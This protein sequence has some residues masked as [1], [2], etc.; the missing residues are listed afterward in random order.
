MAS[1]FAN[2]DRAS[3]H[4]F[5]ADD[6]LLFGHATTSE[7]LHFRYAIRLYEKVSGQQINPKKSGIFFIPNTDLSTISAILSI[8][9]MPQVTGHGKYLGLPSIVGKSKKEVF[10]C[11]KDKVWYKLQGWK[12]RHLSQ[13]GEETLIKKKDLDEITVLGD[14]SSVILTTLGDAICP[15]H[16]LSVYEDIMR[17]KLSAPNTSFYWTRR[18]LNCVAHELAFFAKNMSVLELYWDRSP[19]FLV[20]SPLDDF[21]HN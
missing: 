17:L 9:G 18:C 19:P 14:A 2:E 4:L 1:Q 12:E 7:A 13:A 15:I 6:T 10:A 16:C 5:F 3:L 8:L 21:Q 20:Q 11:I